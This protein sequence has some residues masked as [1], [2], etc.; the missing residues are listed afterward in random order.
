MNVE[1]RTPNAELR[2]NDIHHKAIALHKEKIMISKAKLSI[3][4][5]LL[6]L[7]PFSLLAE[8][9]IIT[10]VKV[11]VKETEG[12]AYELLFHFALPQLAKDA[13]IDYAEL[14]FEMNVESELDEPWLEI[15]SPNPAAKAVDY[16][17]NPVT[18]R[19]PK[20]KLGVTTVALDIT[21]MVNLWVN[22]G[23]PNDGVRVV[24]HRRLEQKTLETGKASPVSES[25]ETKVRVFYTIIEK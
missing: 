17:A 7:L 2:R 25:K 23:V 12:G 6:C 8:V 16:N 4:A 9:I 1:C 19:L 11:E 3:M 14:T 18:A 20:G 24:S 22:Q 21:Q 5:L 13:T 15:L 10:D